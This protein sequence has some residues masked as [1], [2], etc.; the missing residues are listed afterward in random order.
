[1]RSR[2][3]RWDAARRGGDWLR[4][5]GGVPR[6]HRQGVGANQPHPYVNHVRPEKAIEAPE[7][8][9][10]E[11]D[12]IFR[13]LRSAT[14][15][16]FTHYKPN[17]IRRRIQRRMA[18]RRMHEL[19]KYTQYLRDHP[20]EVEVL[21]ED[22]LISVTGFFRDPAAFGALKKKVF[23]RIVN[24]LRSDGAIRVWC[25][26]A[27]RARKCIR[28]RSCCWSISAK[29]PAMCR[30]SFF[31]TDVSERALAKA[32]LGIFHENIVA[33]VSAPRCAVSSPK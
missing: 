24:A 10:D 26:A 11:L 32:R 8:P 29:G 28:W 5:S 1:M 27:R 33:D 13:L 4:G 9:S 3:I 19:K 25:R 23:P 12:H 17:T 7:G 31:A 14:G 16:D 22:L 15:V 18:V 20:E 30:S 21:Y 6:G 2:R